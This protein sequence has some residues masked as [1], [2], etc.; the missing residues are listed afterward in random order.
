MEKHD[1]TGLRTGQVASLQLK[2]NV[3][4]LR[5]RSEPN[6][7]RNF[8]TLLSKTYNHHQNASYKSNKKGNHHAH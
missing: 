6:Q 5:I 7:D 8:I 4:E 3:R 2:V 1:D